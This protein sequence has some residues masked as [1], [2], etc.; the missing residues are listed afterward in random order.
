[1]SRK[2]KILVTVLIVALIAVAAGVAYAVTFGADL[3]IS[4][5][6]RPVGVVIPGV[7]TRAALAATVNDDPIYWSEVDLE[8]ERAAA[9]FNVNLTGPDGPKQRNELSGLVLDQLI[10]QRIIV[11]E[12]RR[13]GVL[14]TEAQVAG[15]VERLQQQFGGEQE[16]QSALAQR[17]LTMA[18]ARRLLQLSLTVRAL[19][20]LVTQVQ[21]SGEEARKYFEERRAQFDQPEQVQVSHILI[22]VASPQDE[23]RAKQ[24][25][26][27]IQG[28]LARGEKF[29]DLAR[30]YSQ[31]PGSKE[32]GG[33]LG[34]V[35]RGS[36]VPE[37][38]KVAFSLP[39]GQISAPVKTQF[40]YHLIRVQQRRP[41]RQAT[42]AEAEG[43]IREQLLGERREAAF[44]KWL[45]AEH[46][47][48]TIKRFPRPA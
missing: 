14:A 17:K 11:Q 7:R 20:P 6:G 2:R 5:G 21:V 45:Q 1:M 4:L 18:D 19:M 8:V 25:I 13:R 23:E 33:D 43:Q 37:F 31:D 26:V 30:Q 12:A 35:A 16:F 22:R 41:A 38:E 9:Q 36:T 34:L 46:K 39:P 28:R 40:G 15:E 29:E 27:L 48:V 32:N 44:Q 24:T 10:D 3:R 47:K 42:F